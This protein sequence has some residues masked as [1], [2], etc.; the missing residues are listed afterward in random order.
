MSFQ[1]EMGTIRWKLHLSAPPPKVF[2]ALA[3]DAGRAGF[4][5]EAA[6]E[7]AGSITFHF[8]DYPPYT[9]RVLRCEPPAL[10]AVDYF[11]STTEFTLR[12]DGAG[13]TDLTLVASGVE[14]SMRTEMVAGWVSVLMALKAHVDHGVDL[15]NH[16]PARTWLQGY[17][18][19]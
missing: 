17:A 2:D 4:W 7:I 18:D 9:G 3:T 10:F 11:G 12:S 5:A 16:D 15:R 1:S 19:N 6:P 8:V 13:G 14:E